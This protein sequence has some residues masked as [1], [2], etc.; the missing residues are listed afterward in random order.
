MLNT[1]QIYVN[2]KSP[3]FPD[4]LLER[5][6]A[7]AVTLIDIL[8]CLDERE[9]RGFMFCTLIEAWNGLL[10]VWFQQRCSTA[11]YCQLKVLA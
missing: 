5:S 10:Y 4:V 1:D 2:M 9:G 6:I 3:S 11:S 8:P 7:R